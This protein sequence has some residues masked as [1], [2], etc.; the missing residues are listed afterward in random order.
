MIYKYG[1]PYTIGDSIDNQL[2]TLE[3]EASVLLQWFQI[4]EMKSNEDKCHLLVANNTEVS[5][6]L[7]NE[8][9]LASSS[10]ELLGV[11]IDNNLNFSEHGSKLCKKSN[12]KLHSLARISKFLNCD[13]LKILMKTFITSQ[14]TYCP[15]TWMFHNRTLNNK[16][17]KLHER[18]LRLAYKDD[19]SSFQELLDSDDAVTIHCRNLQKLAIGVGGGEVVVNIGVHI[20]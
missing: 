13:K 17:N 2:K 14:S 15:L 4:N 16:I 20:L 11:K 7:G 5:V 18:A 1:V 8:N 12:Q 10:V 3:N 19:S 6:T 9:I